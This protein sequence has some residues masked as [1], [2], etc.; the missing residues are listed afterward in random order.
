MTGPKALPILVPALVTT[1][2]IILV[3]VTFLISKYNEV[4]DIPSE[5]RPYE[6]SIKAFSYAMILATLSLTTTFISYSDICLLRSYLVPFI[7]LSLELLLIIGTTLFLSHKVL[8][9][10]LTP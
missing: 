5:A 10:G 8:D 1:I 6:V 9:G 3:A 4:K 2:S 7:F